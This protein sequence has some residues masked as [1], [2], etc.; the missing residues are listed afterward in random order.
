MKYII[1]K[2]SLSKTVKMYIDGTIFNGNILMRIVNNND[3]YNVSSVSL[4]MLSCFYLCLILF[5]SRI[6]DVSLDE[7]YA[8]F[9]RVFCTIVSVYIQGKFTN[10]TQ[11]YSNLPI[12]NTQILK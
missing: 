1:F 5:L 6:T 4:L 3:F 10:E 9:V 8:L 11:H 2:N 12:I 7:G